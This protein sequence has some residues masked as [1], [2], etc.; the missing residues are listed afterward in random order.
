M[1]RAR[2]RRSPSRIGALHN[3]KVTVRFNQI[4]NRF[5]TVMRNIPSGYGLHHIREL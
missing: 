3:T 1:K 4:M 2:P 5:G